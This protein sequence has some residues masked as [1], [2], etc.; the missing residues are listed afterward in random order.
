MVEAHCHEPMTARRRKE[1]ETIRNCGKKGE[2]GHD[3]D[4]DHKRKDMGHAISQRLAR[5]NQS[6]KIQGTGDGRESEQ[7]G[8]SS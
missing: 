5:A 6:W 4:D 8:L 2:C 7:G 1:Q 3:D